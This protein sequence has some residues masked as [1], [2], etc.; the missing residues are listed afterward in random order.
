MYS[1]WNAT[2][3]AVMKHLVLW[4]GCMIISVLSWLIALHPEVISMLIQ[5]KPLLSS[6]TYCRNYPLCVSPFQAQV[7]QWKRSEGKG[8]IIFRFFPM[9]INCPTAYLWSLKV[10]GTSTAMPL[11]IMTHSSQS[12]NKHFSDKD[13]NPNYWPKDTLGWTRDEIFERLVLV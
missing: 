1:C 4:V 13:L 8:E 5:F 10:L 6:R 7:L 9:Q 2:D 12:W 11:D 3:N